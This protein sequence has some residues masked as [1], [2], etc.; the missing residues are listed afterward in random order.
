[1]AP[2][3]LTLALKKG[4][5]FN[6]QALHTQAPGQLFQMNTTPFNPFPPSQPA[7]AFRDILLALP[8]KWLLPPAI[9]NQFL[10]TIPEQQSPFN[11]A[12]RAELLKGSWK[13]PW[14]AMTLEGQN[15]EPGYLSFSLRMSEMTWKTT[16]RRY[17]NDAREPTLV[18]LHTFEQAASSHSEITTI[19][20]SPRTGQTYKALQRVL[21]TWTVKTSGIIP[22]PGISRTLAGIQYHLPERENQ[23]E[24]T[25]IERKEQRE[26]LNRHTWRWQNG[27]F[28]ANTTILDLYFQLHRSLLE[29]VEDPHSRFLM[30]PEDKDTPAN[31]AKLIRQNG[32][33]NNLLE[34]GPHPEIMMHEGTLT[35]AWFD[36]LLTIFSDAGTLDSRPYWKILEPRGEAWK[37]ISKS[38]IPEL[39][40]DLFN[41]R[42]QQLEIK[43]RLLGTINLF[44]LRFYPR[45]FENTIWIALKPEYVPATKSF[46]GKSLA[47]LGFLRLK[48]GKFE[49]ELPDSP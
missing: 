25:V 23:L 45:P 41:K 37:D 48:H 30:I 26:H 42:Y 35:L 8:S 34:L 39:P 44:H 32:S 46:P 28:T 18:L 1:M 36:D 27:V 5:C 38:A 13:S 9:V 7:E 17:L 15:S 24:I 11:K 21:G 40:L 19:L 29:I 6:V 2:D 31:R 43:D 47:I 4:C 3:S 10:Q 14:G 33:A 49:L 16:I 20:D 22:H 12:A